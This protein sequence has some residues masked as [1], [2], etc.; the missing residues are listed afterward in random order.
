MATVTIRIDDQ[1]RD[2]LEEIARTRGVTL[3]E[4]VRDQLDKLLGR[5]VPMRDDAPHT[6]SDQ[7]RLLLA[8]QHEILALLSAGEQHKE[9]YHRKMAL[10]LREGWAGEYGEVFS[11][12]DAE[13]SRSECKLVWDILD[14]FAT[15]QISIRRLCAADRDAL[16]SDLERRLGFAGF[17]MNDSREAGMLVYTR[18]LVGDERW[19]EIGPRL[20]E[21]GN[22]GNS[23]HPYLSTYERMLVAYTPIRDQIAGGRLLNRDD[24]RKV[25]EAWVHPTRR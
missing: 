23:H 24:L 9:E 8:Q 3:S 20:E 1:T 17:D 14:M 10:V 2:E 7:Q 12:I 5:Q 22:A 11:G 16:G 4:L 21:I 19:T 15:L 18:H 6:L 13:M 25:A